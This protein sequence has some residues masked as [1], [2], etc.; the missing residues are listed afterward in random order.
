MATIWGPTIARQYRSTLEDMA[1]VLRGCP[2]ALWEASMWEVRKTDNWMWPP[3]DPAGQAFDDPDVRERKF[4]AMSAVWRMASHALFFVDCDLSAMQSNWAP[5]PPFS[6]NDEAAYVVPPTYSREELLGYVDHC[7]GKVDEVFEDLTDDQAAE[8]LPET[9]RYRGEPF[10]D[11]LVGGALHLL[12][13]STEIRTF[14]RGRGVRCA[15]D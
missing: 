5:P 1:I 13:H 7:R 8:P 3:T 10:S 15:D 14:L 2:P 12:R 4:R 9:H 6:P 11:L